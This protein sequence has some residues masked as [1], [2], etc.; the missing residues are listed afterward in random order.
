[1]NMENLLSSIF[2]YI[3][4]QF[5]SFDFH[6]FCKI[7]CKQEHS[8]YELRIRI[9]YITDRIDMLFRNDEHVNS[10]FWVQIV[11]DDVI[12][13]FEY[14]SWREF[15]TNKLTENA[16]HVSWAKKIIWFAWK[17]QKVYR[18]INKIQIYKYPFLHILL[19]IL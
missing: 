1:M 12:I 3:E 19:N 14:R 2:S 18:K 5:I 13:I 17:T 15:P 9:L 4:L 6:L 11:Q 16:I 7:P 10:C 8:A